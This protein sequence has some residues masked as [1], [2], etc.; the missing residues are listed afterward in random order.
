MVGSGLDRFIKKYSYFYG[1]VIALAL[2]IWSYVEPN[3]YQNY[4]QGEIFLIWTV[5]I[6][7]WVILVAIW[8]HFYLTKIKKR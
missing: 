4:I 5:Y 3:F 1:T 8:Y 7:P 2:I 6:L